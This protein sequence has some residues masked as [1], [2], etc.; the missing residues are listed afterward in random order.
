MSAFLVSAKHIA[1]ICNAVVYD[2][3]NQNI[4]IAWLDE[5]KKLVRFS[6]TIVDFEKQFIDEINAFEDE[7]S[8]FDNFKLLAKIL[9]NANFESM[10]YRYPDHDHGDMELYLS[11]VYKFSM[12]DDI[13]GKDLNVFQFLKFLHCLNYQSCE[14]PDYE[15]S[16]AYKFIR[17]AEE[18]AIY[19]SPEYDKAEWCA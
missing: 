6:D 18:K 8:Y 4:F 16:L 12:R 2:K 11:R 10:K 9:T 1:T 13:G 14:H 5:I 7:F 3:R 19:N 15:K 17:I